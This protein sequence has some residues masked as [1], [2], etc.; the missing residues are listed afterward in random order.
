VKMIRF[1]DLALFVRTAALGSFSAAAREA[2]LLPGQVSAAIQRLER[3]LDICL[4]ARST[5]SLRLTGEGERYLPYANDVLAMLREGR[6]RLQPVNAELEGVL[7]VAAP[8]DLGRNVLLP[9]LTEF[10]RQHP[11]LTMRLFLSDQVTN[12]FRDPVDVALRYGL[13]EDASFIAL[14]LAPK[15][16]RVLAASPDYLERYGRPTSVMQLADHACLLYMLN[17]RVYDN[18]M[19]PDVNGRRETL[20]VSSPLM[21]DDADIVRRWAVA[22][23][24]ILY[25]SWLDVSADVMA[26]RLEVLLPD[27]P[28]ELCALHLVCPHR[29]QFSPGIRLLYEWLKEG[30]GELTQ[31]YSMFGTKASA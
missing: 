27:L 4:F 31:A 7:Q 21:S 29:K 3:E 30:F 19:F 13:M 2:D 25:K 28:G 16:R 5:R 9:R 24:G 8:S 6:E 23:E 12:V 17:G 1:D 11:R 20:T 22:G 15:N 18:W 26:G 10:R 14:P